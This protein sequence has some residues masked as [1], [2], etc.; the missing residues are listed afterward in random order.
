[1]HERDEWASGDAEMTPE[2]PT[3]ASAWSGAVNAGLIK[4]ET[5]AHKVRSKLS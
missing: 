5:H 4:P 3:A 1:M 2:S